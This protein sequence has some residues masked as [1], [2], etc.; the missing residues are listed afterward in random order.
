MNHVLCLSCIFF[1][2]FLDKNISVQYTYFSSVYFLQIKYHEDFEKNVKGKKL[3]VA[4]DPETLRIQEQ[5][6]VISKQQKS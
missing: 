2:V 1:H 5:G 4:D 3:N 6:K